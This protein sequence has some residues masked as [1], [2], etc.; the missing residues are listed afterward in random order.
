VIRKVDGATGIIITVAGDPGNVCG[1]VTDGP[2]FSVSLCNPEAVAVDNSGNLYIADT[3]NNRV[4]MVTAGTGLMTTIAG[5]GSMTF[6]GDGGFAKQASLALP[7]CLWVDAAGNLF[8]CD[9]AH[10]A[11]RKVDAAS[12]IITTVAGMPPDAG[13]GDSGGPATTTLLRA[14][15]AVAQDTAGNL[16]IADTANHRICSVDANTGVLTTIAG[17]GEQGFSGD[18]GPALDAKLAFPDGLAVDASGNIYVSDLNNN[19]VRVLRPVP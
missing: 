2:A 12:G 3:F 11:I 13:F 14:P 9:T 1:R 4:R 16:L 19:R 7:T 8:L 17:I 18:G 10:N 6:N 15:T 5:T